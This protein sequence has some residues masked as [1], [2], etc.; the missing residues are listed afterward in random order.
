MSIRNNIHIDA[1]D[2][3]LKARKDFQESMKLINTP[4]NIE[5]IRSQSNTRRQAPRNSFFNVLMK[6]KDYIIKRL[7]NGDKKSDIA[8]EFGITPGGFYYWLKRHCNI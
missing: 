3:F 4:E 2:D 6:N 7:N 5:K 8:R 1:A